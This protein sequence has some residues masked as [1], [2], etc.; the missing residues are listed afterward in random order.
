MKID[1]NR[2]NEGGSLITFLLIGILLA[3]LVVGGV[4]TVSRNHVAQ[5]SPKVTQPTKSPSGST[6]A[7]NTSSLNPKP[8][9][10]SAPKESKAS[11]NTQA[12]SVKTPSRTP[13]PAT[14]P[15]EDIVS[16][17]MLGLLVGTSIAYIRSI[18]EPRFSR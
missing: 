14:G 1:L 11:N 6:V 9:N 12:P 17:G 10:T 13:L 4:Y 15:S 18:R 3:A 8:K 16:I 7:S 2:A 5:P